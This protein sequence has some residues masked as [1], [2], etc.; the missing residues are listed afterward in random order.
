MKCKDNARQEKDKV[1]LFTFLSLALHC[2][3]WAFV[4]RSC[5]SNTET[6]SI[7]FPERKSVSIRQI[8]RYRLIESC[9]NWIMLN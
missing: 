8:D 9:H 4:N 1:N 3:S 7:H 6:I 5:K 2:Q